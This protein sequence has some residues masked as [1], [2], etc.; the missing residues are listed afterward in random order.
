VIHD[1][2]FIPA[3][4][5]LV[6]DRLTRLRIDPANVESA[7][8]ETTVEMLDITHHP[9]HLYTSLERQ[10]TLRLHLPSRARR[11]PWPDLT[12]A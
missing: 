6:V 3:P 5:V 8:L 10:T 12:E 2:F 1:F 7:I 4:D 11:T 9:C